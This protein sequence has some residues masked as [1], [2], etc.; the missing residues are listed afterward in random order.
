[1]FDMFAFWQAERKF[2]YEDTIMD[3]LRTPSD[4]RR[5]RR[6]VSI[7]RYSIPSL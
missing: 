5:R 3:L 1:M 4:T 2:G 7:H 6:S